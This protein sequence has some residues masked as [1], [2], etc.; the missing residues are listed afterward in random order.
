MLAAEQ[1][2]AAKSNAVDYVG[3]GGAQPSI[4]TGLYVVA[5]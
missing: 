3:C 1:G 4:P 5:A 2:R